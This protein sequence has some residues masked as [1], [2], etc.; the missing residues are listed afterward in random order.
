M[1]YDGILYCVKKKHIQQR[2]DCGYSLGPCGYEQT[3]ACTNVTPD[4][5]TYDS[6]CVCDGKLTSLTVRYIGPSGQDL[7]VTAKKCNVSLLDVTGANTGDVYTIDAANAGLLYLRKNT[8]FEMVGTS[9]G[10]IK[11]PTNCCDNPMGRVFF[12]FEVIGWTD[13]YGNSC[14]DSNH[15]MDSD[16][17]G[18]VKSAV[19]VMDG[20]GSTIR[21]Y[22]N[23]ADNNSTF[24]FSVMEAQNVSVSIL[25]IKG[26]IVETIYNLSLIHI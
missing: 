5:S 18:V 9:F 16:G 15:A 14:D 13:T 20:K 7:S 25:N 11:I 24:E 2:L 10:P 8:Y 23:P 6:Q 17:S 19:S 3:A 12:P 4:T 21:Q 26:Q 22:P 1:C